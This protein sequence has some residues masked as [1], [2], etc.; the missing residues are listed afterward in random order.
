MS[1][2]KCATVKCPHHVREGLR[3]MGTGVDGQELADGRF[4]WRCRARH[5]REERSDRRREGCG[6]RKAP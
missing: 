3:R 4:C 1:M 5:G 6:E 2:R